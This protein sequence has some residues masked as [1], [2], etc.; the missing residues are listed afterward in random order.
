MLITRIRLIDE[1]FFLLRFNAGK[2]VDTIVIEVTFGTLCIPVYTH[3]LSHS[4]PSRSVLVRCTFGL[5]PWSVLRSRAGYLGV[6][7][8]NATVPAHCVPLPRD[9]GINIRLFFL[10][11]YQSMDLIST[12]WKS[13]RVR[14]LLQF[15]LTLNVENRFTTTIVVNFKNCVLYYEMKFFLFCSLQFFFFF[16]IQEK[17]KL[18]KKVI[19]GL[20]KIRSSE[21]YF[22]TFRNSHVVFFDILGIFNCSRETK[23]ELPGLQYIHVLSFD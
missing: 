19:I 1:D 14:I 5:F 21:M 8:K 17:K 16:L 22:I 4:L 3:R 9:I 6:R 15:S 23:Y 2:I 13:F 7:G 18:R 12:H 10:I 20:G 11:I